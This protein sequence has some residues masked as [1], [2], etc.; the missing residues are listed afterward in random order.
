[1]RIE[2]S[3]QLPSIGAD[4]YGCKTFPDWVGSGST[5]IERRKRKNALKLALDLAI[6]RS[7]D[8]SSGNAIDTE[9]TFRPR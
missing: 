8:P 9:T 2:I 6:V 4:T 5:V 3:K 7:M 1:M